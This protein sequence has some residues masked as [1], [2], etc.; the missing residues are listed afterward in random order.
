MTPAHSEKRK[1]YEIPLLISVI[2][3]VS[4]GAKN[5]EI[6][7]P[8]INYHSLNGKELMI[9]YSEKK[10]LQPFILQRQSIEQKPMN[11]F[12]RAHNV[13]EAIEKARKKIEAAKAKHRHINLWAARMDYSRA[14]LELPDCPHMGK[15]ED[16]GFLCNAN[17]ERLKVHFACVVENYP[18]PAGADCPIAKFYKYVQQNATFVTETIDCC[19]FIKSPEKI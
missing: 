8:H 3:L 6:T 11:F 12:V 16:N 2:N 10:Q 7:M 19:K 13:K 18:T 4:T 1:L 15:G 14:I 5:H 17:Y 9:F